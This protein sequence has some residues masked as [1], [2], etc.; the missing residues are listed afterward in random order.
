METVLL[1]AVVAVSA[2]MCPGMMWWNR[3]RGRDACCV[4]T[5][6]SEPSLDDLRRRRD[7]VAVAIEHHA[8]TRSPMVPVPPTRTS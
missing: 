6:S 3:R 1:I 7:E 2:L 8:E 4:P 5:R